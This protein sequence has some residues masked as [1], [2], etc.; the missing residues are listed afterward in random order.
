VF[1]VRRCARRKG[2]FQ[3]IEGLLPTNARDDNK[4]RHRNLR[5]DVMERRLREDLIGDLP[6]IT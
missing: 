6:K 3:N 5:R 1:Q 4:K 2:G